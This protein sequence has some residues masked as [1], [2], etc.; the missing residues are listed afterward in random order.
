MSDIEELPVSS[1]LEET[2]EEVPVD[3]EA[4]DSPVEESPVEESPVEELVVTSEAENNP[5]IEQVASDIR[6]ILSTNVEETTDTEP[7]Q[8][9]REE[10]LAAGPRRRKDGTWRKFPEMI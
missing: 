8:I 5:V 4:D 3:S 7:K 9:T 2:V 1:E 6:E 10:W